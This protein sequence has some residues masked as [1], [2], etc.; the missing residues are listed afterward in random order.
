MLIAKLGGPT[1]LALIGVMMTLNR[2]IARDLDT[3]A[4]RHEMAAS[5]IQTN[6]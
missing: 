2:N 5:S 6:R 1:M 4:Q 3:L